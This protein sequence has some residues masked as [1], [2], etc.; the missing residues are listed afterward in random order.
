MLY[1]GLCHIIHR[2]LLH[3]CWILLSA[4]EKAKPRNPAYPQIHSQ[5]RID[6]KVGS[7]SSSDQELYRVTEDNQS[8]TMD[9]KLEKMAL[10]TREYTGEG[11][12]RN[13]VGIYRRGVVES[14]ELKILPA[15]SPCGT[16]IPTRNPHRAHM[17]P[18]NAHGHADREPGQRLQ[19]VE[20]SS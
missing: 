5:N 9:C 11:T 6:R 17:G 4:P 12:R 2:S 16:H 14:F 13:T 8:A 15:W 19:E 7:G 18:T 1:V 20:V 10:M 3:F